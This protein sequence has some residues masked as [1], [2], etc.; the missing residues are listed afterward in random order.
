MEMKK[1]LSKGWRVCSVFFFLLIGLS[2]GIPINTMAADTVKIG[3]SEAFSGPFEATGRAY[4]I[5]VQFAVDEQNAK[6]GLLG[7][8]IELFVEDNELKPDVA[9]RKTKKHI[10]E[11]KVDILGVG[12]GSHNVLAATKV[13]EEYKKIFI[14][15]GGLADSLTGKDFSRYSFRVTTNT[16]N[17]SVALAKFMAGKPYKRFYILCQDYSYGRDSGKA[18]KEQLKNYFPAAQIVGEDYHP[19]ATKDFAPYISKVIAAK[20]DVIFTANWGPDAINL[21]KQARSLGLKRPFP[22]ACTVLVSDPYV[23]NELKDDSIGIHVSFPHDLAVKTPENEAMIARFHAKH[24]NEKDFMYWWPIYNIG[25]TICGWQMTFA[26]IEKAGSLDTEKIINTFEGFSYKTPVGVWTMRKC[27]HQVILPMYAGVVV[28]GWNPWFN[29]SIDPKINFPWVGGEI[30][31]IPDVAI[32]PTPEYN[33][34]CP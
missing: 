25:Y 2:A 9:V 7:K 6:G 30:M 14:N 33:P 29:G 8:K 24:K 31:M 34:R 11:N 3:I 12:V 20:A 5:G 22:F 17:Y 10:L 15:Y 4:A 19:L 27:D 1:N 18:F 28:P 23:Q 16:H 26:A 32:P 13:A 21:V